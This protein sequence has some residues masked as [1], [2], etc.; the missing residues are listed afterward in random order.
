M[1][2]FV[3]WV[4]AVWKLVGTVGKQSRM[5]IWACFHVPAQSAFW[6]S[7]TAEMYKGNTFYFFWLRTAAAIWQMG[8]PFKSWCILNDQVSTHLPASFV[9]KKRSFSLAAEF[10][11]SDRMVCD[12]SPSINAMAFTFPLWSDSEGRLLHIEKDPVFFFQ[13]FCPADTANIGPCG[14][15]IWGFGQ[16]PAADQLGI[17]SLELLRFLCNPCASR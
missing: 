14:T 13:S 9:V 5:M 3:R 2:V 12:T 4:F 1:A 8:P 11:L 10:I 15:A 16:I 17:F 7:T 6:Y